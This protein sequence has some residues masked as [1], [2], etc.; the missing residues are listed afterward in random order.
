[1]ET[2]EA[3]YE[4]YICGEPVTHGTKCD[5]DIYCDDCRDEQLTECEECGKVILY[6]DAHMYDDKIYCEACFDNNFISCADCGDVVPVDDAI[7]TADGDMICNRCFENYYTVCRDCEAVVHIDRSMSDERG[8]SYCEECYDERYTSC[9]YCRC[10]IERDDVYYNGWGDPC[11]EECY[12]ENCNDGESEYIHDSGYRPRPIFKKVDKEKDE[13]YFGIELEVAKG[14]IRD[15]AEHLRDEWSDD[16]SLFFMKEDGSVSNGYEIVSHPFTLAYHKKFVWDKMFAYLV[17]NGMRSHN[18]DNCGLHIHISKKPIT[19]TEQI[20]F[21][22]FINIQRERMELL[23]RRKT[24][25][26]R[27]W[28]TFKDSE[29]KHIK[30]VKLPK[31]DEDGV[32]DGDMVYK[33]ERDA[34][35]GGTYKTGKM[36]KKFRI[37]NKYY[38]SAYHTNVNGSGRYECANFDP[39]DTIEVRL[40]KGTLRYD[41]F[42]AS[43]ELCHAMVMYCKETSSVIIADKEKGWSKFKE[44]LEK[45]KKTYKYLIE[46]MKYRN[47]KRGVELL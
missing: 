34:I 14:D 23:S 7:E 43:I 44:F 45:N 30:C 19:I 35:Y 31:P 39:R 33:E 8:C 28:A 40:F 25:E 36:C 41:T 42:I 47:E 11:C 26:I 4:C 9:T 5:G 38:G 24:D 1:M 15:T 10:E 20:R 17:Q 46:Y 2:L 27:H 22:M 6:D 32:Y 37:G 18:T 12:Y 13:L 21:G 29:K 16:E 3:T